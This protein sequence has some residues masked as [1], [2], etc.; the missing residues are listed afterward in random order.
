[1]IRGIDRARGGAVVGVLVVLVLAWHPMPAYAHA[2]L[3]SSS[4]SE[5][6]R[7]AIAPTT[8]SFEF[9]EEMSAPA[10]VVVT[11]PDDED[12]LVGE[13]EV[14]GNVVRQQVRPGGSEG[15]WTTAVRAVSQDGHP[16]TSQI[17]FSVGADGDGPAATA[18][19]AGTD[20][21]AT[22]R[23]G[24]G[25]SRTRTDVAVGAG[26]FLLAGLLLVLARR[27]PR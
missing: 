22:G 2:S 20:G 17:T 27:S 25:W 24:G 10:Y 23:D 12:L 11:P 15:T 16:V 4:P 3:V 26:L 14:D 18:E 1:V 13:P 21:R 5:G 6:E 19:P 8:V 9:S 7:L